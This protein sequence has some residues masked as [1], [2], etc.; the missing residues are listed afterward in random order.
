MT[1]TD[2]N[3]E[4]FSRYEGLTFDDVVIVPGYSDVLPDMVDT[5]GHFARDI[6]LSTPL[7][8]AAMDRVTESRLAIAIARAGGIGIVHRNM[9]IDE[10]ATEVRRV[11][12]AQS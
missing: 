5:T 8:S 9:T 11:K 7:V 3:E 4:F 2:R 6:F 12:R 1:A 10:Q